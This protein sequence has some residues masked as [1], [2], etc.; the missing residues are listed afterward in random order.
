[1]DEFGPT[2]VTVDVPSPP[3]VVSPVVEASVSVPL[4]AVSVT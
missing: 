3:T 4:V 2:K 1:M